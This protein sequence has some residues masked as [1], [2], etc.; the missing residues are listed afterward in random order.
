MR[1]SKLDWIITCKELFKINTKAENTVSSET[2][3]TF[4]LSSQESHEGEALC[5]VPQMGLNQRLRV[6]LDSPQG[7]A[8]WGGETCGTLDCTYPTLQW[9]AGTPLQRWEYEVWGVGK[10]K[11]GFSDPQ[12]LSCLYGDAH[13]RVGNEVTEIHG[14]SRRLGQEVPKLLDI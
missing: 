1:L 13:R 3:L 8:A 7:T 5:T 9:R 2:E 14:P 6:A 11:M 12:A 10:L 4:Y